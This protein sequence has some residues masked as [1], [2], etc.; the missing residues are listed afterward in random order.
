MNLHHLSDTY[1]AGWPLRG[2]GVYLG[3]PTNRFSQISE[4]TLLKN[5]KNANFVQNSKYLILDFA[6]SEMF[7]ENI[8]PEKIIEID[9]NLAQKMQTM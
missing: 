9:A 2:G 1:C 4:N 8:I 6:K 5:C 7:R 3:I